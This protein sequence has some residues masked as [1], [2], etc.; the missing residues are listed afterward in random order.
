[1]GTDTSSG[2]TEIVSS[3][4]GIAYKK[5]D[6]V[7]V[8]STQEQKFTRERK[9]EQVQRLGYGLGTGDT[10][11]H[12]INASNEVLSSLKASDMA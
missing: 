11:L 2:G 3:Y 5:L 6:E 10:R 8:V 4:P 7:T 1:M 9:N 12:D